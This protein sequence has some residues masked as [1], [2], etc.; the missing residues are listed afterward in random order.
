LIL[1]LH[2]QSTWHFSV[3]DAVNHVQFAMCF[4]D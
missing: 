3:A 4:V 1:D 2:P